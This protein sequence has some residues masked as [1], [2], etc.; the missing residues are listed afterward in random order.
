M[1][2]FNL[3]NNTRGVVITDIASGG[4]ASRAGLQPMQGTRSGN[5]AMILS[6]MDI[7][8]AVNGTPILGIESLI[9]FLAQKTQPGDT[10]SMT[11]LRNGTQTL[12][13]SATLSARP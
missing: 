8:T 11:I 2:A 4:P 6:S 7:I 13:L 9:S 1:E 5:G 10:I 12:Q 3:P